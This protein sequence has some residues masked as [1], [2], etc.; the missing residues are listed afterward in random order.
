[1]IWVIG[2]SMIMM[3]LMM[4]MMQRLAV[5]FLLTVCVLRLYPLSNTEVPSSMFWP[6]FLVYLYAVVMVF[7]TLHYHVHRTG[8]QPSILLDALMLWVCASAVGVH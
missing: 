5:S 4:I 2:D 6:W 8:I 1:M 3:M 7:D